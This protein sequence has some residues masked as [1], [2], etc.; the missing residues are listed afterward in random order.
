MDLHSLLRDICS[1]IL[2]GGKALSLVVVVVVG[3]KCICGYSRT[4]YSSKP[5]V[6]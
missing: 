6:R 1:G 3:T 5:S 4:S 2:D